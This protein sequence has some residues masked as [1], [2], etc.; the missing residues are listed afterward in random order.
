MVVVDHDP[1]WPIRFAEL[2]DRLR[3]A[4]GEV[5]LRIDHIGST[6]V[7]DLAAKP[8]ID[9]QISVV[10]LEPV[11][12]FGRWRSAASPGARTTRSAPSASSASGRA[13]R[14]RTSTCAERA[15]SRS[16]SRSC[17]ARRSN[18]WSFVKP[19]VWAAVVDSGRCQRSGRDHAGWRRG[20]YARTLSL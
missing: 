12:P 7:P 13:T 17:S 18:K 5:A 2:G 3:S 11:D 16:S 15:A 8:I 10:S 19:H 9:V 20:P 6:A 4:L 14:A 1:A